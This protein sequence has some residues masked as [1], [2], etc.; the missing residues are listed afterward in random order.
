M[1]REQAIEELPE[2]HAAALS[3]RARGF[4]DHAIAEAL[5]LQTEAVPTLLQIADSKL[6]ALIAEAPQS[7]APAASHGSRSSEHTHATGGTQ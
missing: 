5:G 4:D 1:D 6:A 7:T 3:L 2:A